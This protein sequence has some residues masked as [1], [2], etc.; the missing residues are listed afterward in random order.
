[1]EKRVDDSFIGSVSTFG[2]YRIGFLKYTRTISFNGCARS[3]I[4]TTN[5]AHSLRQYV[6]GSS[7]DTTFQ[8]GLVRPLLWTLKEFPLQEFSQL[9][10][11]LSNKSL[12]EIDKL[13]VAA[14]SF[15]KSLRLINYPTIRIGVREPASKTIKNKKRKIIII[16][17]SR[18]VIT[19]CVSRLK[20]SKYFW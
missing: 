2:I 19:R 6:S 4:Y 17:K 18:A 9:E 1:M 15:E 10:A 8:S 11:S 13:L 14:L 5:C 3:W 12:L 20:M 16:A 7:A